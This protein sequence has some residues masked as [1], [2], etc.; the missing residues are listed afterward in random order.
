MATLPS[1]NV[2]LQIAVPNDATHMAWNFYGQIVPLQV[3]VTTTLK[4]VKQELSKRHLNGIPVNK[5]QLK[6]VTTG[7]FLNNNSA[8]LAALN[9]GPTA[10]LELLPKTRGG[11]K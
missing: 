11:R 10:T 7:A 6:M 3:P 5:I 1:P 8:S 9:L 4:Q 2:T